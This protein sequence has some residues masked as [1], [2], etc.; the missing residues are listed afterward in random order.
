MYI[1]G[2]HTV[3]RYTIQDYKGPPS[4]IALFI[5]DKLEPDLPSSL[6]LSFTSLRAPHQTS[7]YCGFSE[8]HLHHY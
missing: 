2:R 6:Y 3:V 5:I 7:I 1:R 4:F 8:T